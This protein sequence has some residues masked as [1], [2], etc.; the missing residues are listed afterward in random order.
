[1]PIYTR[2]GA[3]SRG[4]NK[5]TEQMCQ[6]FISGDG[7]NEVAGK[8]NKQ[9]LRK[10]EIINLEVEPDARARWGRTVDMQSYKGFCC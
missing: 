1:M 3:G 6:T 7:R 2:R 4:G 5:E 8:E 10:K 9:A